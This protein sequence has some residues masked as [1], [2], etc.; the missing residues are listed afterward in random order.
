MNFSSVDELILN[1]RL[2]QRANNMQALITH[3]QSM[4]TWYVTNFLRTITRR[5]DR[6]M[7][8]MKVKPIQ[9]VDM[10][11]S[12]IKS[13]KNKSKVLYAY[14]ISLSFQ[15]LLFKYLKKCLNILER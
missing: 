14:S 9:F 7:K 4:R 12:K 8:K 3:L 10:K 13:C 1:H 6:E 2:S 5:I 11:F 15:N